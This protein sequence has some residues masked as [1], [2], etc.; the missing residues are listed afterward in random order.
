MSPR[1]RPVVLR[2]ARVFVIAGLV[3]LWASAMGARVGGGVALAAA[4]TGDPEESPRSKSAPIIVANGLCPPSDTIWSAM[5]GLVPQG[6]LDALP[7][8]ATVEVSDLGETYRVRLV[9]NGVERIR[10]YRDVARD[11]QQRARFAAVFIVLTLM[12]PE[13]LLDSPPKLPPAEPVIVAPPPTVTAPPPRFLQLELSALGDTAP[14]VLSSPDMNSAGGELRAALGS[15]RLAALV[16]VG[17]NPRTDFTLGVLRARE[18]RISFDVGIRGRHQTRWI[19]MGGE[20][21]LVAA[22]FRAEGLSPVVAKQATRVD[23]GL[24]GG[25]TLRFGPRDARLAPIV[26]VHGTYFP[27]PYEIAMVPAGVVGQTPTF[28]VGASLGIAATF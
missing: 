12:P 13:L 2:V 26:G 22:L 14:A 20:A 16:G 8:S 28:R 5:A 11:C 7:R 4:I 27:R 9:T 3:D 19:E 23:G 10:V 24:R 25:I 1:V 18:Q 6:A 21:G 17:L 15:G